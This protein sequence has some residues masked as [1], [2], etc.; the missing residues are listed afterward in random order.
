[1]GSMWIIFTDIVRHRN[2]HLW[3]AAPTLLDMVFM[4]G[5]EQVEFQR[6]R[7][8][9]TRSQIIFLKNFVGLDVCS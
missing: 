1:M 7:E 5:A 2:G 9:Y 4:E 8:N 3:M 6:Y